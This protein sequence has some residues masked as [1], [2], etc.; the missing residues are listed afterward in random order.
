MYLFHNTC[1]A[2]RPGNDALAVKSPGDWDLIY[3]RNNIWS[4]TAYAID[5]ANPTQPLDLDFDTLYTTLEDE[6]VYWSGLP[7][8]HLR[9]LGQVQAATGQELNGLN[10]DPKFDDPASGDYSL[11]PG[12]DLIDAGVAI[13]GINGDYNGAAPDIGAFEYDN[14]VF[15][16]NFETG[17]LTRWSTV[18]PAP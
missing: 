5:N 8:R 6:L 4:A 10:A 15:S 14:T 12:S 7:D 2:A 11:T 16:D 17:N 1:D 18:I 3:S 9:T 13:P